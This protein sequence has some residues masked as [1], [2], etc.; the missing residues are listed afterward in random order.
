MDNGLIGKI[1]KGK[2][3]AEERDKRIRFQSF[4]VTIDGDNDKHEVVFEEGQL[5]CD[6]G[7]YQTRRRCSHTIALESVLA[8]MLVE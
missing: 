7:F 3:Y 2:R 1:A 8:G 5:K 4:L 6:C